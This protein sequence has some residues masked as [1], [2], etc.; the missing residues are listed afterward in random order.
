MNK[1]LQLVTPRFNVGDILLFD[2]KVYVVTSIHPSIPEMTNPFVYGVVLK[3][4]GDTF[5]YHGKEMFIWE[6]HLQHISD[7]EISVWR[8]LFGG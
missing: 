1:S 6:G 7:I 8:T 3:S 4:I 5:S 2:K